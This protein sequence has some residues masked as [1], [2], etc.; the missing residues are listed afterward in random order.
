MG[1]YQSYTE[2]VASAKAGNQ[3]AFAWLY[4]KTSKEKYYI[5]IKYMKDPTEASDVLQD[6]YMKAW[7]NLDSLKEPE[8][9]PGWIGQIVANTALLTLRKKRPVTFSDMSG[10]NEEGEEFVYDI[11]DSSIERQPELNYTTNERQEIIR[12]MIDSLTDEQ[13]LCIMMYYVEEMSV[14]EIAETLGCSENTVK[15]RLNYGRKNIRHEADEMKKKGYNFYSLAPL[16]LLLLLLHAEKASAMGI[17]VSAGT[18]TATAS[19]ATAASAASAG[20]WATAA[21]KSILGIAIAVT[22][23][24]AGFTTVTVVNSLNDGEPAATVA[25]S[26][27]AVMPEATAEPHVPTASPRPSEPAPTEEPHVIWK[28][29][30]RLPSQY[31][32]DCSFVWKCTG[33]DHDGSYYIQ[34]FK[35]IYKNKKGKKKAIAKIPYRVRYREADPPR[36]DVINCID[37]LIY[38]NVT[39]CADGSGDGNG[40]VLYAVDLENGKVITMSDRET[41][42]EAAYDRYMVIEKSSCTRSD[43]SC[44][45]CSLYEVD[46]TK[47]KKI[48]KLG[49]LFS[50][51]FYKGK[52][53]YDVYDDWHMK[54]VTVYRANPDGSK[55]KKLFT[56]R[57][58][59]PGEY[60]QVIAGLSGLKERNGVIEIYDGTDKRSTY[61]V[62][63]ASSRKR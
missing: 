28:N 44:I 35:L 63:E 19:G 48:K 39:E 38:V 62:K 43:A 5:A 4:D 16:P 50:P 3:D 60:G 40:C 8:K 59:G 42:V 32:Y 10:E 20:F 12:S 61:R 34:N 36:P 33:S 27:S 31:A 30:N 21:G 56:K 7:Q 22:T 47:L 37:N 55:A 25:V 11:E 6:A 17:A 2:A 15:S 26:E 58:R 52:L 1:N 9:F 54:R 57:Y 45:D 41:N 49:L 51:T 29:T 14:K 13:R 53:Y 46:G 24:I 23:G 18:T